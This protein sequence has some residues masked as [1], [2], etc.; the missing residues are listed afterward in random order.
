MGYGFPALW[1]QI[2][3]LGV[4]AKGLGVDA[5]V[6]ETAMLFGFGIVFLLLAHLSI[7]KQGI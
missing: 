7:R 5:F 2:V 3:S 1:F 4:F 6:R